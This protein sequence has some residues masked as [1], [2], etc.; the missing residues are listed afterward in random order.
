MRVYKLE[1]TACIVCL[2]VFAEWRVKPNGV[3]LSVLR[4]E[5]IFIFQI[6]QKINDPKTHG[7]RRLFITIIL[8]FYPSKLR[9]LG[10]R[11]PAMLHNASNGQSINYKFLH[12]CSQKIILKGPTHDTFFHPLERISSATCYLY[13]NV[14]AKN[15]A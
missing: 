10:T 12:D 3:T 2:D 8:F 5:V 14:R 7:L 1:E 4:N 9:L 11:E 15:S 13:V 6:R